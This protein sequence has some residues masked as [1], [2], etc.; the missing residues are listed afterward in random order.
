MEAVILGTKIIIKKGDITEE[1]CD[2][3]VNAA[4]SSLMGGGGVDGA[5]HTKGGKKIDEECMQIRK[6]KYPDG[7]P[8]GK[9]VI[10]S[11]GNLKARYVMHTVGPIWKGGKYNEKEDLINCYK[12]SLKLA[13]DKRIKSIAFPAISTGAYGYPMREAASIA[14]YAVKNFINENPGKIENI[15]FVLFTSEAYNEFIDVFDKILKS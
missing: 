8:T 7:L 5:I 2:V 11:G 13:M 15:R 4:N 6:D 12:N 1:D 9:V 10:T 14:L 3:L